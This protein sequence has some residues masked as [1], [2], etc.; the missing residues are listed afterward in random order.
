MNKGVVKNLLIIFLS[1]CLI[2]TTSF[3]FI[4]ADDLNTNP[5]VYGAFNHFIQRGLTYTVDSTIS[6]ESQNLPHSIIMGNNDAI[7]WHSTTTGG[8]G[9]P[10]LKIVLPKI[11]TY[12]NDI[13]NFL[14]CNESSNGVIACKYNGTNDPLTW[15][16]AANISVGANLVENGHIGTFSL[17]SSGYET[18]SMGSI[19]NGDLTTYLSGTYT[20]IGG[21]N[22]NF[23][24]YIY[25]GQN[26]HFI[27]AV[28]S[29]EYIWTG[30]QVNNSINIYYS[31]LSINYGITTSTK[32]IISGGFN[33]YDI[34]FNNPQNTN[35][36]FC[37]D[38]GILNGLTFDKVIPVWWGNIGN[39]TDD[40]YAT[41]Y[42][43]LSIDRNQLI[44]VN[45]DLLVTNNSLITQTNAILTNGNSASQSSVNNANSQ[46]ESL[47]SSSSKLENQ[48]SQ[49]VNNMSTNLNAIDTSLN[50]G[51]NTKFMSGANFIKNQVN[52]ITSNFESI[53]LLITYSL[54]LGLVTLI[55]GK[56][57][58]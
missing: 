14:I 39:M 41:F 50:L 2:L 10:A 57:L 33:I 51:T 56:R 32:R 37:F 17:T 25:K 16:N 28:S 7:S 9:E 46:N 58:L 52:R 12:S 43:N 42:G 35:G 4:F 38:I 54:I 22:R 24:D 49:F 11:T 27:F 13:N 21:Y 45:N 44:Q 18:M 53:N 31:S 3:S 30:A 29:S 55:I 15:T 34:T 8:T 20:N 26:Q 36:F 48:E 6:L 1:L 47:A 40:L 19:S 23:E 5:F